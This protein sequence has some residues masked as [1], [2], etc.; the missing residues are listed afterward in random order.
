MSQSKFN[1][2][3][4]EN[5]STRR[6]DLSSVEIYESRVEKVEQYISVLE[7]DNSISKF[8]KSPEE[9]TYSQVST[10]EE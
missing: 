5:K 6:D 4:N 8:E 2:Y 7:T 3:V 10:H 9:A 1:S